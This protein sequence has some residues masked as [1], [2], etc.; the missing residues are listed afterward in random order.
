MKREKKLNPYSIVP[1]VGM[2]FMFLILFLPIETKAQEV[3]DLQK[4]IETGLENNYEIRIVRNEQE[5]SDNNASIGNAGML[6]TVDLTA[7]YTGN[8]NNVDNNFNQGLNAGIS[9]NWTLFDGLK[10]QTEY[11]RLKQFKEMGELN[12]RFVIESLISDIV[13]EYYNY[14]RQTIRLRNL[15]RTLKLSRERLRISEAHYAIGSMSRLDLQQARVYFNADSS[16][17]IKQIDAVKTAN[18]SLNLLM[19]IEEV[20]SKIIIPDSIINPDIFLEENILW[21]K[22]LET[23]S[24]LLLSEKNKRVSELD[25]KAYQSRNLPYLKVNGGYGYTAN[26]Y[27]SPNMDRQS[28]L[29]FNY[30]VTLGFNLFDGMNRRREQR[31]AKINIQNKEL[32]AEQLK[33]SLKSDF[34]NVWMAYMTNI[35]LSSLERENLKVAQET[36]EIAIDRYKLGDLSGIE[37]REAQNSLTE[38]E[39]RL[40]QAEYDTKLCEISLL[41][42][43]GQIGSYIE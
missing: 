8:N 27:G 22:T 35:H 41:Q 18:I 5:I 40:L 25:L 33:L 36:F 37:L 24:R 20:S 15:E 14:V 34:A 23:N 39:D 29:G 9:M 43:S 42:I 17:L 10:M 3:F 26:I 11:S 13:S 31:N 30:G 1:Q 21:D 2:I 6:P 7:A 32:E 28:Y 38:A 12:S 4:A 16:S 19:G